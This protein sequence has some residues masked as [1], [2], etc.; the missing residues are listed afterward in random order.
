MPDR[1]ALVTGATPGGIGSAMVEELHSRGYTVF[2]CGRTTSKL[3][4]LR[5]DGI[6]IVE[7]DVT[8]ADSIEKAAKH[9]SERT[10]GRLHVLIN[11]R[12]AVLD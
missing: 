1:F 9:V 2:A 4:P 11:K 3:E 7:L 10:G 5:R 12:V 8:K 6:E